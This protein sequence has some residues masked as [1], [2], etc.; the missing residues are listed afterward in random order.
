MLGRSREAL[1]WETKPGIDIGNVI[2]D[3]MYL[4]LFRALFASS[5]PTDLSIN[6][7]RGIDGCGHPDFMSVSGQKIPLSV[8]P[9]C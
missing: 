4:L 1:T 6:L 2:G 7:D 5:L 8:Y 3:G 9:N